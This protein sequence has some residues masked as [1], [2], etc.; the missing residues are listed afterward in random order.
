MCSDKCR[1][2][3]R[4]ARNSRWSLKYDKCKKCGTIER[5]HECRGMCRKCYLQE[6]DQKSRSR[7]Y[8]YKNI[9]D[10]KQ[11]AKQKRG[12]MTKEE[13]RKQADSVIKYRNATYFG[14]NWYKVKGRAGYRCEDCGVSEKDYLNKHGRILAVHHKD[15]NKMNNNMENLMCL[16]NNCHMNMHKK[17][18]KDN[19]WAKL[20][21]EQVVEIRKL[22]GFLSPTEVGDK[23]GV[24]ERTI[25]SIWSRINWKHI[26]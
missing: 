2:K 14:G 20:K 3:S 19:R 15:E 9:E 22:E 23:Y 16:C 7:G 17:V 8:Y 12:D 4:D 18:G 5:P 25:R 13:K 1:E 24:N 11:R 26:E 6:D 21:T 10:I